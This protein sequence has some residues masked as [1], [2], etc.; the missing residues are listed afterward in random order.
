MQ[1]FDRENNTRFRAPVSSQPAAIAMRLAASRDSRAFLYG[2]GN[3]TWQ[4]SCSHSITICNQ[5]FK[6][7]I[8]LRRT[9][10]QPLASGHRNGIDHARNDPGCTGCT[11]TQTHTYTQSTFHLVLQPHY[12]REKHEVSCS[13]FLPNKSSQATSMQP[14]QCVLQHHLAESCHVRTEIRARNV[15]LQKVL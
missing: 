4:Y 14:A 7:H 5:Q 1:S 10:E 8:K 11:C 13:G 9:H 6:K 15:A 12:Y 2:H 3:R